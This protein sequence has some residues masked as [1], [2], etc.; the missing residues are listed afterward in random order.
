MTD[1]R[2]I[3]FTGLSLLFGV[4]A[5]GSTVPNITGMV[6]ADSKPLA[7][8][9]VSDGK[10]ITRTDRYGRYEIASDK[11]EGTVFITTPAGYVAE[12]SDNFQPGFWHELQKGIDA[13]DTINFS[14]R[15]ENQDR[16]AI[17][18]TTD[19]HLT[20]DPEK[21]DLR[22]YEQLVMPRIRQLSA[23]YGQNGPVYSFNLGDISH[24]LFWHELDMPLDKVVDYVI[25]T[26]YP[27]LMY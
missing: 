3:T 25:N 12:S 14:L 2:V 13:T 5:T 17:L 22:T 10:T 24:E 27:T 1:L 20:N 4:S 23:E 6:V 8:V 7:G 26:G 21:D 16:F 19:T 18:F 9:E 11:H 15:S